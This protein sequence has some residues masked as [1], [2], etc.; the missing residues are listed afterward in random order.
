MTTTAR[1]ENRTLADV[2]ERLGSVAPER[3]AAHPSPGSATEADLLSSGGDDDRL[4]E[5]VDGVLVEKA[6]G[7]RESILAAV[8]I[9]LLGFYL[10]DHNLG[11]VSGESGTLRLAPGLVRIPDVAF[12]RWER[13]SGGTP[14]PEAFP[15]LAPDLAVEI[16]SAGNTVLEM[17]RKLHEYFAAGSRL[18]W[19]VYP[20][21]KT[22][23][24]Y[25]SPTECRQF[26]E[27]E[28]LDGGEVLPGFTV[29]VAEWFRRAERP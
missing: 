1:L 26:T 14:G 20:V 25:T 3:I 24:V 9:R 22:V 28:T 18:V 4:Y 13:F 7:Y 5:L 16:L 17:E 19:Y 6:M 23:Q 12:I 21:T 11:V 2:L 27:G 15:D 29:S 10:E 8:L